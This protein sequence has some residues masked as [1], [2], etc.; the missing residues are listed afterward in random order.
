MPTL[1][2]KL[3]DLQKIY[4]SMTHTQDTQ[5]KNGS[6]SMQI[7]DLADKEFRAAIINIFK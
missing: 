1:S 2:P 5:W 4:E 6:K 7:V 3:V